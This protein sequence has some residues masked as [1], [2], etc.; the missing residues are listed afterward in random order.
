MRGDLDNIYGSVYLYFGR[1]FSPP[2][3]TGGHEHE[4]GDVVLS[5]TE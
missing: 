5:E 2:D 4:E 1:T 3:N